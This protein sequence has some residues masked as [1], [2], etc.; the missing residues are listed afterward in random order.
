MT[1]VMYCVQRDKYLVSGNCQKKLKIKRV[2]KKIHLEF[3]FKGRHYFAI[4]RDRETVTGKE[5]DITVLDWKLE[6]L[7][8]GNRLITEVDGTL[9]ANVVVENKGQTELKLIIAVQLGR[10]L[11]MS[12]FVGG[13]CICETPAEEGW[14]DLHPIPRHQRHG[15]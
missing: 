8:Y 6:R 11:N 9:E 13:Q 14:E 3:D 12:C 7:L 15:H 5:F 1:Y 10:H 4:V 2:M